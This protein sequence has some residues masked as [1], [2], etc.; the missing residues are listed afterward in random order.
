[1][2]LHLKVPLCKHPTGTDSHQNY[3]TV[4]VFEESRKSLFI[5]GGLCKQFQLLCETMLITLLANS[6]GDV[7]LT[8]KTVYSE[9]LALLIKLFE[10]KDG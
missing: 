9:T 10:S 2:T 6:A 3:H 1:M 5:V 7:N 8:F 4:L